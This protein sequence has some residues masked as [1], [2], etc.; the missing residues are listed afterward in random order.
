MQIGPFTLKL[1]ERPG[2]EWGADWLFSI[3]SNMRL[4]VGTSVTF[5]EF[6]RSNPKQVSPTTYILEPYSKSTMKKKLQI[7]FQKDFAKP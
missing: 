3:A 6:G 1:K 7:I 2:Y 5:W 4:G